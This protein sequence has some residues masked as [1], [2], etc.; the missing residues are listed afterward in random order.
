MTAQANDIQWYIA[1]DGKQHGPLTD[2]EMRTFV[3]HNYLQLSDMIWRPGMPEWQAAPTVFPTAFEALGQ[4]PS[5]RP[6][7]DD[8]LGGR[9][10]LS[11]LAEPLRRARHAEEERR[12]QAKAASA[13][14]SP[15]PD[16]KTAPPSEDTGVVDLI[17]DRAKEAQQSRAAPK[18]EKAVEPVSE[19]ADNRP[20][21]DGRALGGSMVLTCMGLIVLSWIGLLL[22]AVV[23]MLLG[24]GLIG[25]TWLLLGF[26]LVPL[27][28]MLFGWLRLGGA[29]RKTLRNMNFEVAPGGHLL[30]E[31]SNSHADELGLRRP[32]I[33][34]IDVV[35]A[36]A[37]GTQRDDAT[38][39]V[40]NPLLKVM[41]RDE[42]SAVV[43]HEIGHVVNGDM[44]RMMFMR[45][46]QDSLVWY[47]P[48]QNGKQFARWCASWMAELMIL[49][50]SRKR[51]FYADAVG[52]A[53]AGK[54]AMISALRKLEAAPPLT[55][56]ENTHARF[57]ARGRW[58]G[59]LSTH[60]SF[61][62]RVRALEME[63][64]L[65]RLPRRRSGGR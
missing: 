48:S 53:L 14:P 26:F 22:V 65:R 43:G 59:I 12:R 45:T 50:H 47:I 28:G 16:G 60:P 54:A 46:F 55:A 9:E 25:I 1:R 17:L 31:L 40:G 61:N 20:R 37:M 19:K 63:Q 38:I 4:E 11:A 44:M 18:P 3:A 2:V 39:A 29:T 35:N 62:A 21:L 13:A 51:E 10:S 5:Y 64:Y 42:L 24:L 30:E 27:W 52:A 7:S 8:T 41:T 15:K 33:G 49:G 6:Q 58:R 36:F 56:R 32:R 34:T 57:M 23:T